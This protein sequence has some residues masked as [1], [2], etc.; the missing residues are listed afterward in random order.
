MKPSGFFVIV[1][2]LSRHTITKNIIFIHTVDCLL[3]TLKSRKYFPL[4]LMIA[5]S[6]C[7]SMHL[8]VE[9]RGSWLAELFANVAISHYAFSLALCLCE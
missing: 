5:D 6:Q 3:C 4:A 8:A 2:P 9:Q 1:F 7:S